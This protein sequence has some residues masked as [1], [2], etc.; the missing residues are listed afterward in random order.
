MYIQAKKGG[1]TEKVMTDQFSSS[2]GN[3]QHNDYSAIACE[4]VAGR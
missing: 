3:Y 4:D 2:R 1:K